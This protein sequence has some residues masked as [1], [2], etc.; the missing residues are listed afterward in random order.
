ML[1]HFWK[2]VINNTQR[3]H[4][5]TFS[6][7]ADAPAFPVTETITQK[8]RSHF[9]PLHLEVINESKNHNVPKNSE[10]HFKV[11]IVSTKFEDLKLI[12]RHRAVNTLLRDELKTGGVHALSIK[13]KTPEQWSKNNTVEPSPK[14][15]GGSKK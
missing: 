13:A 3:E 10:T 6:A 14:C 5:A 1:R 9:E 4:F 12:E 2:R 7:M 8:L 15:L 11:I